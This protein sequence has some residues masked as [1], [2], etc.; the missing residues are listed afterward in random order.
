MENLF[1]PV[2]AIMNRLK[3][4]Q[5]FM[6]IGTIFLIPIAV[7]LYLLMSQINEGI[8][9]AE[10]EQLGV[11]YNSAVKSFLIDVQQHRGMSAAFLNGDASFKEKIV[12]KQKDLEEDIRNIDELDRKFGSELSTTDQWKSLKLQWQDIKNKVFELRPNDSFALH[13]TLISEILTFISHVADTSNLIL[14]P[15][16]DSYYLMNAVVNQFPVMTENLG[17]LRGLGS[18]I[19]AEK[20]LTDKQKLTMS[21][22]ISTAESTLKNIKRDVHII[23]EE[24]PSLKDKLENLL[25]Q[26]ETESSNFLLVSDATILVQMGISSTEYFDMATKTIGNVST[27]YETANQALSQVLQERID[28]L[29]GERNLILIMVTVILLLTVYLITAF[30]LSVVRAVSTLEASAS[31]MAEGDLTTRAVLETKDELSTI[32]NA[33]NQMAEAFNQMISSN[34]L[35]AEQ[36]AASAE[37]LTASSEQSSEATGQ[38]TTVIQQI[39]SGTESQ[40]NGTEES[41]KSLEEITSGIQRIA[42]NASVVSELTV[43]TTEQA[44]EGGKSVLQTVN[45]MNSIHQSVNDSDKAIRTLNERSQEIGKIL[46]VISDIAGQTNLL[47][48]NAAI[49]AAHAGEHGRGFAVVAEEVRKLAAQSE[50]YAKQIGGMVNEIQTDTKNSVETM[51]NVKMEVET[52]IEISQ[53]TELKFQRILESVKQ[54]NQQVLDIS[55]TAQQSSAGSEEITAAVMEIA[56]ISKESASS[57]QSVAASAEEQLASMEE[58]T[59]SAAALSKMAEELQMQISRFKV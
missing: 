10:K 4:T 33:F 35:I 26:T 41:A 5:K 32:G 47:A 25:S 18:G 15:Q 39:A 3:F 55:A 9:F 36:V 28:N 23:I 40:M 38:I 7:M 19:L 51:A 16:L 42:E 50:A 8:R 57:T 2:V 13:T 31:R 54:I 12:S 37:Q 22:L 30:Y 6:L 11:N 49:E 58:I 53:A 44:E 56:Q 29:S 24:H 46:H 17:Q 1:R 59:A 43:G 27:F 14:D 48:L 20:Q 52:G 21:A 34:K 45:Q